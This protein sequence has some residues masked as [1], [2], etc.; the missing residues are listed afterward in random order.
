MDKAKINA[1]LKE[2]IQN[3]QVWVKQLKIGNILSN[4]GEYSRN[5]LKKIKAFKFKKAFRYAKKISRKL[6]DSWKLVLSCLFCFLFFYYIIG[7]LLVENMSIRQVYQL[8]KEKSEKHLNI[9]I[10]FKSIQTL[11]V[12]GSELSQN[13]SKR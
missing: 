9:P 1:L 7:S 6:S 12:V 11:M 5:M 4:V 8:P 2:K 10:R 13:D 3:L